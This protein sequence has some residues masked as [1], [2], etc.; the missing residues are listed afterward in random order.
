MKFTAVALLA[1]PFILSGWTALARPQ[2]LNARDVEG[3]ESLYPRGGTGSRCK[4]WRDCDAGLACLGSKCV[5][6]RHARGGLE[7]PSSLNARDGRSSGGPGAKCSTYL[8][9]ERG[10]ACLAGTCVN[11]RRHR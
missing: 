5:R 9:C 8:D 7:E 6:G 10:L 1:L 11:A 3:L 2:S 4:T